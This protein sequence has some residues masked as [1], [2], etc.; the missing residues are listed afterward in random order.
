ME[1]GFA[2]DSGVTLHDARFERSL[3]GGPRGGG[4]NGTEVYA[5]VWGRDGS[6]RCLRDGNALEG[7]QRNAELRWS[8]GKGR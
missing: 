7:S 4:H 2:R 1:K 5:A 8:L 3:R 6:E